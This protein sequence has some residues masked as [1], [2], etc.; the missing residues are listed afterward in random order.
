[1]EASFVILIIGML[2]GVLGWAEIKRA[3]AQGPGTAVA[4]IIFAIVGVALLFVGIAR[5]F[6]WT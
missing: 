5:L 6:F 2:A 1:M 4:G 3:A